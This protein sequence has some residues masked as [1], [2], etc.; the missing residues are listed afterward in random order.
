M[1]PGLPCVMAGACPAA[2]VKL[3]GLEVLVSGSRLVTLAP[4]ATVTLVLALAG[5][6][7]LRRL[8]LCHRVERWWGRVS[9]ACTWKGLVGAGFRG[10]D[11]SI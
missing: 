4:S 7:R 3:M 9:K 1:L 2:T 10:A 8:T 11:K 6:M 5:W